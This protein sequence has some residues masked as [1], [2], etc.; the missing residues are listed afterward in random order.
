L[1][2]L[3][4]LY[5]KNTT[6]IF[7]QFQQ[8]FLTYDEN[9]NFLSIKNLGDLINNEFSVV[10]ILPATGLLIKY[11]PSII[12]IY[13]GFGLL[14]ITTLFSY[15]PYTQFWSVEDSKNIWIGSSTNRGKIQLEIEFENLIRK[16]ENKLYSS[17]FISSSQKKEKN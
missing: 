13:I 6:I 1:D 11:D 16:L 3:G 10:D 5:N 8:T 4:K 14:M 12:I 15:L 2:N 7:D 9:G 17:Y